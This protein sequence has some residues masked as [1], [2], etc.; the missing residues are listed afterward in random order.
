MTSRLTESRFASALETLSECSRTCTWD[1]DADIR[2]VD[3]A[4]VECARLCLDCAEMCATCV[5]LL[6]RQSS[7]YRQVCL[8]C[9]E[10]CVACAAECEKHPHHEH[11]RVCAELCRRCAEQCRKLAA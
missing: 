6:A 11:C 9:A 1:A 8:V 10:I 5:T 4:M 3:V 7:F 2:E